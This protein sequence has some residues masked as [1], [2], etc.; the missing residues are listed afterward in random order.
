MYK[1]FLLYLSKN[2]PSQEPV[3][4]DEVFHFIEK[5]IE[6]LGKKSEVN[7]LKAEFETK[8]NANRV[9]NGNLISSVKGLQGKEIGIY[10]NKIKRDFPDTF[11]NIYWLSLQKEKDI[12]KMLENGP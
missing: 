9:F 7:N 4:K 2:N 6:R 3:F 12:R 5:V 10:L 11:G 8:T 1:S